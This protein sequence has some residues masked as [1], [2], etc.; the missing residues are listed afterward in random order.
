MHVL[1]NPHKAWLAAIAVALALTGVITG[2][3]WLTVVALGVWIIAM[4]VFGIGKRK[5]S[6]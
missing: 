3:K 2:L 6:E 4:A 1:L 5:N